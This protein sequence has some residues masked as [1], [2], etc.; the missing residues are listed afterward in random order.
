MLVLVL[1]LMPMVILMLIDARLWLLV[2]A[3]RLLTYCPERLG[4]LPDAIDS[5]PTVCNVG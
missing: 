3:P 5:V 1:V 2:S 4:L